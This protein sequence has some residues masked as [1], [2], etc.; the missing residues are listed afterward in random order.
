MIP[1]FVFSLKAKS[2]DMVRS[3]ILKLPMPHHL[4][5]EGSISGVLICLLNQSSIIS[6]VL[7]MLT[8][9]LCLL[10]HGAGSCKGWTGCIFCAWH[11]LLKFK[12]WSLLWETV[13]PTETG[14]SLCS[15]RTQ[16]L[17]Y[18][19]YKGCIRCVDTI[20]SIVYLNS[21]FLT[22]GLRQMLWGMCIHQQEWIHSDL[23]RRQHSW[24]ASS[25]CR[26]LQYVN[27]QQ[28]LPEPLT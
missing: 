18:C 24:S 10:H 21:A 11:H 16:P 23:N 7:L 8:A 26:G 9:R 19:A 17:F 27:I 2:S 28:I 12:K 4:C 25:R 20:H 1:G 3:R 22:L 5:R 6:L 15:I 13:A 14:L